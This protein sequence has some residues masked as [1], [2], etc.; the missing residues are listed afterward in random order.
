ME[1]DSIGRLVA[2]CHEARA[3]GD[4]MGVVVSV[5]R[6]RGAASLSEA[7]DLEE[8][9]AIEEVV[10]ACVQG[11]LERLRSLAEQG[12]RE[13]E[14]EKVEAACA[15]ARALGGDC[16]EAVARGCR[17]ACGA[18]MAQACRVTS[19][20]ASK[21]R[22]P[23]DPSPHAAALANGLG[24]CCSVVNVAERASAWIDA[25][26]AQRDS[27]AIGSR[28]GATILRDVRLRVDEKE[29]GAALDASLDELSFA[30]QFG[31]RF[32]RFSLQ[33]NADAA[34]LSTELAE[35]DSLYVRLEDIYCD[36]CLA[37]AL[38]SLD[39][40]VEAALSDAFFFVRRCVDRALATL[41]EQAALARLHRTFAVLSTDCYEAVAALA[42]RSPDRTEEAT[43]AQALAAAVD[44][45]DD[46]DGASP[47]ALAAA[48]GASFLCRDSITDLKTDVV[49]HLESPAA[50]PL[51]DDFDHLAGQFEALAD[52]VL[53]RLFENFAFREAKRRFERKLVD[54]HTD[55]A[56]NL[57]DLCRQPIFANSFAALPEGSPRCAL[58]RRLA[59]YVAH[60][61]LHGLLL[62]TTFLPLD[63]LHLRR[64]TRVVL[65]AI[66]ARLA[67]E[68]GRVSLRPSFDKLATALDILNLET[69][70]DAALLPLR[71]T[72]LATFDIA[73]VL[74]RRAD[75][76]KAAIARATE[77]A[78]L[79][80]SDD[81]VYFRTSP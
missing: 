67:S 40:D 5:Q 17:V 10:S 9:G 41:S 54:P 81:F 57:D 48:C 43:F 1:D 23:A 34:E 33:R 14:G 77:A 64:Q 50:L 12:V 55:L 29:R 4:A 80:P 53:G 30:L 22:D 72:G 44:D 73:A 26:K 62:K 70:A 76:P 24:A 66:D 2:L 59:S 21:R 8:R 49:A 39:N 7:R 38:S 71:R 65:E 28:E 13:G 37:D 58:C 46:E 20:K 69:P 68:R 75:F 11:A 31:R 56:A 25:T 6:L 36:A 78:D 32:E 16:S 18:A 45:E 42:G 52:G 51:V 3:E 47:C 27:L 74:H 60:A 61:I 35:L 63:A 15:G 79:P 19:R